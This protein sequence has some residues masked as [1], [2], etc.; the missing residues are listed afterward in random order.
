MKMPEAREEE[1]KKQ[2]AEY[3]APV[4]PHPCLPAYA[5]LADKVIPQKRAFPPFQV[6]ASQRDRARKTQEVSRESQ[7]LF[8]AVVYLCWGDTPWDAQQSNLVQTKVQCK[9]TATGKT[10]SLEMS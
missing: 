4:P 5:S 10:F 2:I 9:P 7:E 8:G 3:R 1:E 6:Q